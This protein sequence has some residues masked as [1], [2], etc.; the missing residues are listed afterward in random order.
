MVSIPSP[1]GPIAYIRNTQKNKDMEVKHRYKIGDIVWVVKPGHTYNQYTDKFEE[2]GFT[3]VSERW[4][5]S[6]YTRAEIWG[7]SMHQDGKDRLY[8]I[9]NFSGTESLVGEKAISLVTAV[10]KVELTPH[11]DTD[12]VF[13]ELRPDKAHIKWHP[14]TKMVTL[15]GLRMNSNMRNKLVESPN[16]GKTQIVR[17]YN[18]HTENYADYVQT[19][20]NDTYSHFMDPVYSTHLRLDSMN[21]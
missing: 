14:D 18:P 10:K 1:D 3:P 20:W 12:V 19:G 21:N 17:L 13:D 11:P 5:F 7:T 8:A 6:M 16:L 15:P 4:S 9:R 2:I